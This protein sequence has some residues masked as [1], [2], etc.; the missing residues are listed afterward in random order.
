MTRPPGVYNISEAE[1]FAEV[2]ALSCSGAKLL[3]PPS[4]PAKFFYRQDHA[5]YKDVWDFGS[6]AHAMVLGTGP[7][8]AEIKFDD[9]KKK[10]A[11]EE[12]DAARA[13]GKIPLLSKELATVKE[14]AAALRNHPYASALLDPYDGTPEQSLFWNHPRTGIPLRSRLDQMP[15]T[16][17]GRPIITDYKSC[18]EADPE[19]IAKAVARYGYHIQNAFYSDGFTELT[20]ERPAFVFICQE[21]TPPYLVN[22][23]ELDPEAVATGRRLYEQAIT[24]YRACIKTGE[25]PGYADDEITEIALPGWAPRGEEYL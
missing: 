2:D 12:R 1:Y 9:W 23:V 4:C 22:V 21:K 15:H 20:G 7:E 17:H 11:Q 14:M 19:S 10:A 16:G 6:G 24:V 25:W 8:I 3:L 13:A 18:H 5:E